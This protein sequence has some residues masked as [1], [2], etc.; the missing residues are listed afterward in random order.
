[1]ETD[2]NRQICRSVP[3]AVQYPS[4][5]TKETEDT[6]VIPD[7]TIQSMS[8]CGLLDSW[9]NHPLRLLGPWCTECS[10][11]EIQGVT[12]FND[13][14][15]ND[16]IA[17]ELLGRSDY[18]PVLAAKYMSVIA[19]KEEKT[20]RIQCFEMFLANDACISAMDGDERRRFLVMALKMIEK[21]K[22]HANETRHIMVGIMKAYNYTPFL[23][24]T[25]S[26]KYHN[27]FDEWLEGY[28]ICR[29]D[30]VEKYARQ[31]LNE[32]L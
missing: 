31:F 26:E 2:P 1:M 13:M 10:S 9:L 19:Q 30:V 5:W 21:E 12:R 3:D 29:F 22:E 25:T 4:P 27:G 32:Y 11:L 16:K 23:E 15:A 7:A 28:N 14:L 6:F 20:G 24:E 18:M 8:T 17:V